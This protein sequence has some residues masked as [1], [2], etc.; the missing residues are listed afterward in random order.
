MFRNVRVVTSAHRFMVGKLNHYPFR[1]DQG[2]NSTFS[3]TVK[4]SITLQDAIDRISY[5]DNSWS[6]KCHER[7]MKWYKDINNINLKELNDPKNKIPI[8]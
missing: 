5:N 8:N 3:I 2:L 4:N 1:W 6:D 7:F